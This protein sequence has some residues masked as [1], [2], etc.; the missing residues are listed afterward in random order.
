MINSVLET[1]LKQRLIPQPKRIDF[2]GG[3]CLIAGGVSVE[4]KTAEDDEDFPGMVSD[5]F[6]EY[7]NVKPEIRHAHSVS[8]EN[9][10]EDQ[11]EVRVSRERITLIAHCEAG[12]ALAMKTLRQLAEPIRGTMTTEGHILQPCRIQDWADSEFR[13]ARLKITPE[14]TLAEAEKKIRLAGDWKFRYVIVE[15][16][17][18]FPFKSHP[19]FGWK[20]QMKSASFFRTL[21]DTADDCGV[22]LIP[23]FDIFHKASMTDAGTGKHAVLNFR[24]EFAPLFEPDGESWCMSN[25]CAREIIADLVSE[26]H[27]FFE[28]PDYFHIGRIGK[29]EFARCRTCCLESEEQLLLKQILELYK[30]FGEE[31]PRFLVGKCDSESGK[32]KI[33]LSL[34]ADLL[35]E[36]DAGDGIPETFDSVIDLT[37]RRTDLPETAGGVTVSLDISPE[38]VAEAAEIAWNGGKPEKIACSAVAETFLRIIPEMDPQHYSEL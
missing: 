23:A 8:A 7:W 22:S 19:E 3:E 29:N 25:P 30:A 36:L 13:S 1:V 6:R 37:K 27:E 24:R 31:R 12:L 21:L 9:F 14:T 28:R 26:L 18:V 11:Y 15:S 32:E 33:T 20:D 5:L 38:S 17:G 35:L 34:P 4:I 16:M 10:L 2:R